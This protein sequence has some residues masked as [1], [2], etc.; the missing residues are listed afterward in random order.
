MTPDEALDVLATAAAYDRRTVGRMDAL[1]WAKALDDVTLRDAIDAV[2]LHYRD[3]RE[4][5][6]PSD[7]RALVRVVRRARVDAVLG[8]AAP[9]P[10]PPRELDDDPTAGA[11]WQRACVAAIADGHADTVPAAEKRADQVLGVVRQPVVLSARPTAAIAAQVAGALRAPG[12]RDRDV[13]PEE[14]TA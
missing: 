3:T 12:T 1:A 14:A 9:I 2:H 13:A 7:V 11:R 10:A 8:S 5:V 6:M 4:F